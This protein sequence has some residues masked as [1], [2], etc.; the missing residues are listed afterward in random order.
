MDGPK[1]RLRTV[2]ATEPAR[3][4]EVRR[5]IESALRQGSMEGPDGSQSRW[6]LVTSQTAELTAA[7][8]RLAKRLAAEPLP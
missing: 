8:R 5:L 1:L 2:F 3:E 6:T 4:D 7:E